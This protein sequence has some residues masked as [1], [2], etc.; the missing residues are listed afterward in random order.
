MHPTSLAVI[1][2]ACAP[3]APVLR[4]RMTRGS[5]G[6]ATAWGIRCSR[7][8]GGP[9]PLKFQ[10]QNCGSDLYTKFLRRGELA[11]CRECGA[12]TAVPENAEEVDAAE[13]PSPVYA[14]PKPSSTEDAVARDG[15]APGGVFLRVLAAVGLLV[16]LLLDPTGALIGR[17]T[18]LKNLYL[19]L[20][21][22]YAAACYL[23]LVVNHYSIVCVGLWIAGGFYRRGTTTAGESPDSEPDGD[24]DRLPARPAQDLD[25]PHC[26]GCA[27]GTA[28]NDT[29]VTCGLLC[30]VRA[31]GEVC[32]RFAPREDSA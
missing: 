1:P 28:L 2:A 9:M 10:C 7:Q 8:A 21:G 26:G 5:L 30:S 29:E 20:T 19:D 16:I 27:H 23:A 4:R 3:G 14:R 6:S 13:I 25:R 17:Q 11:A 12:E 31:S 18:M 24:L 32:D 22:S 15:L